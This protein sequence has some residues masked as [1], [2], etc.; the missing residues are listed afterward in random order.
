MASVRYHRNVYVILLANVLMF[1]RDS[2]WYCVDAYVLILPKPYGTNTN[3][4]LMEG[5]Q[6]IL[7][8][9]SMVLCGF[10]TDRIGRAPCLRAS[11]I[12]YLANAAV[13][14]VAVLYLPQHGGA[15]ACNKDSNR[16][17]RRCAPAATADATD[18]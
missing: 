2:L 16:P 11:A 14:S 6:G 12:F 13:I 3:V 17:W 5:A 18:A 7:M 9:V 10:V 8:L 15:R 4:G 1:T